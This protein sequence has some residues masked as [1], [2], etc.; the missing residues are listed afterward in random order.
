MNDNRLKHISAILYY[1]SLWGILEATL[2]YILHLLPALIAGSIMFPIATGILLRAVQAG[3]KR[4]DLVLIGVL[5]A[6]IKSV[7]LLLPQ[8]SVWKTINPMLSILFE[9]LAVVAVIGVVTRKHPVLAFLCLPLASI[10]WR[11]LYLGFSGIQYGITGFLSTHLEN[12]ANLFRFLLLYGLLSGAVAA[13]LVYLGLSL[14][15]RWQLAW[16]IKALLALPALGLA[17]LLTV[18][19]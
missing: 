3:G 10:F 4:L 7:N 15:K 17:I 2:G 1:G 19:L 6:L 16:E 18:V 5:A 13:F 14:K 8:I 9:A 12:A 11:A